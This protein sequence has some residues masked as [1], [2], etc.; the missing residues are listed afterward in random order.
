MSRKYYSIAFKLRAVAVAEAQ[1]Y[2]FHSV[3]SYKCRSRINARTK[4][5]I[6]K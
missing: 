1:S 4:S 2:L 3:A 6:K 5:A